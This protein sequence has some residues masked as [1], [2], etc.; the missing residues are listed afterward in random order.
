MLTRGGVAP[1]Y[2]HAAGGNPPPY[3]VQMRWHQVA[4]QASRD[5][6]Y[7][8][9][10]GLMGG[11]VIL[12]SAAPTGMKV[13]NTGYGYLGLDPSAPDTWLTRSFNPQPSQARF[14]EPTTAVRR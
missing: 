10:G 13:G 3:H 11:A 4:P 14:L 5:E 9:G 12:T 8:R 1:Q 2:E 7:G 6:L